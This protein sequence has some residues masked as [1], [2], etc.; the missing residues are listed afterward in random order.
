MPAWLIAEPV[1]L[2]PFG[3]GVAGTLE[4][5]PTWQVSQA[6]VVGM[7]FDGVVTIEK[8]AAGIAKP[9]ATVLPWH[10]AQLLVVLGA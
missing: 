3:T 2:L 7:W 9:A 6:A 4:P 5:A 8:F 1:N 10:C